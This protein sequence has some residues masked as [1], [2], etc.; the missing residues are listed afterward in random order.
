MRSTL[1]VFNEIAKP[2]IKQYYDLEDV[3]TC[4]M[5]QQEGLMI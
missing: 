4:P 5:C 2:L 3:C 1:K